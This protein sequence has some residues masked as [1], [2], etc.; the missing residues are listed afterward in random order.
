MTFTY[1]VLGRQMRSSVRTT[2]VASSDGR[3]IMHTFYE[4][5]AIGED[6]L[7]EVWKK[8]WND[9]GFEVKVLKM[10]DAQRHPYCKE[11]EKVI[12][13]HVY[14]NPYDT[15]CYYRW[16]AMAASGGGWMCD[17]DTF[18]TNF[19]I[20]EGKKLPNN[21]KMTSFENHVPSLISG[22]AAEWTRVAKLLVEA[23]PRIPEDVKSDMHAFQLLKQE[24]TH[25]VDFRNSKMSISFGYPYKKALKANLPREVDCEKMAERRAIHFAHSYVQESYEQGMFPLQNIT[26]VNEAMFKRRGE[27]ARIF[28]ADWRAQCKQSS[29]SIFNNT[30]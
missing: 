15:L 21:G 5:L 2:S 24:G 8:E 27:A 10:E 1:L 9:A 22:T 11:M 17:Y 19:S 12:F 20:D 30:K 14:H 4:K 25:D 29:A 3:P 6:D 13:G 26:S 7:L 28:L 16:L 23:I 18:P